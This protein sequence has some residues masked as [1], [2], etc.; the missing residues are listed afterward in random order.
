MTQPCDINSLF[1]GFGNTTS[2]HYSVVESDHP[3]KPASVANYK[4]IN[5]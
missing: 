1:E 2:Q 4:V 5:K 3:Y